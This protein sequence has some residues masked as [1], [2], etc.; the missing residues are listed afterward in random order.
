M[1]GVDQTLVTQALS[2][3]TV[4]LTVA[5]LAPYDATLDTSAA[6]VVRANG[7][8]AVILPVKPRVNGPLPFSEIVYERFSTGTWMVHVSGDGL[9]GLEA[10]AESAAPQSGDVNLQLPGDGGEASL[11][12]GAFGGWYTVGSH[13]GSTAVCPFD[14][15]DATYWDRRRQRRCCSGGRCWTDYDQTTVRHKCGC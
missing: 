10:Q 11:D 3:S 1:S 2:N 9:E 6:M 14:G 15:F 8:E 12:C 4:Q 5:R 7:A 13:C